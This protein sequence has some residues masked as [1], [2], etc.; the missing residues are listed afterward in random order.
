MLVKDQWYVVDGQDNVLS[1]PY[2]DKGAA[3]GHVT[4]SG[5]FVKQALDGTTFVATPTQDVDLLPKGK[6]VLTGE[7]D[8]IKVD[9]T[10]VMSKKKP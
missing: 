4:G 6:R 2:T 8:A 3:E 7:S 1:G 10:D 9:R 5:Q